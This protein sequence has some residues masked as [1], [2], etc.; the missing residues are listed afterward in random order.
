MTC[1]AAT[2]IGRRT[3]LP[4]RFLFPRVNYKRKIGIGFGFDVVLYGHRV[5][6]IARWP[7]PTRTLP[8]NRRQNS[9]F[10]TDRFLR[11]SRKLRASGGF[12]YGK[13]FRKEMDIEHV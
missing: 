2:I 7:I 10:D 4:P 5:A 9:P 1:D 3:R 11:I 13:K 12:T 6:P 8:H